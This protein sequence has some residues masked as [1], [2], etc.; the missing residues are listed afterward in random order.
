M[1]VNKA[2]L[3]CVHKEILFELE[4]VYSQTYDVLEEG[5][6]LVNDKY[7]DHPHEGYFN[8]RMDATEVKLKK[9]EENINKQHQRYSYFLV[10]HI[11]VS[12]T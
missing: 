6:N 9:L 4:S 10:H 8:D 1:K 2:L 7:F 11:P 5:R 12:L 3:T